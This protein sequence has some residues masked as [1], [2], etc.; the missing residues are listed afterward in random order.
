MACSIVVL[1][2]RRFRA[3]LCEFNREFLRK[4]YFLINTVLGQVSVK[5]NDMVLLKN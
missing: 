2:L 3:F 5:S 4:S 1:Y